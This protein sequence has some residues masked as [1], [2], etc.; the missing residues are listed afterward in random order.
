VACLIGGGSFS[1][2]GTML[3]DDIVALLNQ[4]PMTS[5]EVAKELETVES[6]ILIEL[7]ADL[8]GRVEMGRD[9][10]WKRTPPQP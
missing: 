3:A 2:F 8:K 5:E 10:K 7:D 4:K 1:R 9:G 6:L